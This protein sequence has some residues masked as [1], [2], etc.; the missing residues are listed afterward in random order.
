M[1]VLTQQRR[2]VDSVVNKELP[3]VDDRVNKK[4]RLF[5]NFLAGSDAL[6]PGGSRI[7]PGGGVGFRAIKMRKPYNPGGVAGLQLFQEVSL[8][9]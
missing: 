3:V 9:C 6:A 4:E 2:L 1:P 8:K 5:E 7:P